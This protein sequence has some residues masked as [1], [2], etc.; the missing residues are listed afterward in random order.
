[1]KITEYERGHQDAIRAAITWLHA[2]AK[3]MNDPHARRLLDSAA[4]SLGAAFAKPAAKERVARS[5]RHVSPAPE[6]EA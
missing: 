3:S 2:E 6:Q 4:D 5:A 1:M